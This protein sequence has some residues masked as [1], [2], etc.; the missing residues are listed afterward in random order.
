MYNSLDYYNYINNN[1]NQP[2][3]TENISPKNLYDPY[4]GFIRG[5]LFPE[6]YNGYKVKPIELKPVN[7]QAK[8]LTTLDALCFTLTDLNLYLDIYPDDNDMIN[9][10]N[11][12]REQVESVKNTYESKYGPLTINSNSNNTYPF[13]WINDPW[14][15]MGGN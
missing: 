6:L 11:K 1:Y 14:P 12:Y 5:N 2:L 10:F 4:E 15:W 3:Y 9:L 8:L 13:I 7:E